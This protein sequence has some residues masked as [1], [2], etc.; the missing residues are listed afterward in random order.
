MEPTTGKAKYYTLM[1]ALKE[2]I[3]SGTIKPGQKLPS[4][5]ELTREYALSRHTVRKALALLENEGYI[6]AQH[7]KGTFCSERVIQRHNSKKHR[8]HRIRQLADR[9]EQS[10]R[11]HDHCPSAGK[12]R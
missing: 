5:N 2:Q 4:E 8:R 11:D 12:T 7:G 10:D 9:P 1:E 6:T 3:L